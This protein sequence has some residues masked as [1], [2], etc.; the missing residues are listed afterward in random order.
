MAHV[1]LARDTGLKR[2]VAVKVLQKALAED[3]VGRSRFLREAQAA[4]R[5]DHPAVTAVYSVGTLEN[6]V[7]YI[8]MQYVE[9][10]NLA[11]ANA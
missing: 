5:I 1:F 4:A 9:G 7:P 11:I 6:V 3:P 8:E 10:G 2:L